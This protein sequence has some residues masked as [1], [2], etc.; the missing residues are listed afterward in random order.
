[1][2][3]AEDTT[4]LALAALTYRGYGNASDAEI[5]RQLDPWLDH[6][7]NDGLGDWERVWGPASFRAPTS[8]V[9]DAMV[10]VVKQRDVPA[11]APPHW[12]VAVRGTNPISLFDWVF[13]DFWVRHRIDWDGQPDVGVSAS[14]ALGLAIIQNL[15]STNPPS[16]DGCLAAAANALTSLAQQIGGVVTEVLPLEVLGKATPL[17][18]DGQLE[19]RLGMITDHAATA[20]DR[21]GWKTILTHLGQATEPVLKRFE[22]HVFER[23]VR[24]IESARG[25]GT[26]LLDF[27]QR[28]VQPGATVTV[29]GHSKGG[30]LAPATALWLHEQLA[31]AQ[32]VTIRCFAFAGP[33]PGDEEFARRYDAALGPRTRCIV[34][35]C[36]IVPQA[37]ATKTLG[38]IGKLYPLLM[39]ATNALSRSVDKLGYAHIPKTRLAFGAKPDPG[40]VVEQLVHN[41]M[42]AYLIA[43]GLSA[44]RWRA[45]KIFA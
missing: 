23:M 13:G 37:W 42:D 32:R 21:S 35:R 41:H 10:Y 1:M 11:G 19:R 22:Q 28:T 5:A 31:S 16:E 30:A 25:P 33:T 20:F 43:A 6:M 8:L 44:P 36:D 45:Q 17:F 15:T 4:M 27:L 3:T 29:T 7:R 9:D 26:T 39:A 38:G 34:N 2:L 40:L 18:D 12:V 14:T 24:K